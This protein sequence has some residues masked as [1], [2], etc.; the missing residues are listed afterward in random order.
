MAALLTGFNDHQLTDAVAAVS[1]HVLSLG[2]C[3]DSSRQRYVLAAARPK[4]VLTHHK[5]LGQ[6]IPVL[7]PR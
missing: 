3:I 1:Q 6:C 4:A 2:Q 7:A 5:A